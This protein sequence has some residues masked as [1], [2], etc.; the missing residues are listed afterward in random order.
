MSREKAHVAVRKTGFWIAVGLFF[1]IQI[2][3]I[4]WLIVASFRTNSELATNPFGALQNLTLENY[5]D[6]IQ[7]SNVFIY[8]KNS[9]VVTVLSLIFI[10][11]ISSMAA[12]A[13]SRIRFRGRNKLFGYFIIGL[14]IPPFVT[15]I[16]LY[17]MFSK[18]GLLNTHLAL[19]LVYIGFNLPISIL[20]FV[21]FYR[22]IPEELA[23]AA[24]LDGCNVYSIYTK[25][26][27]PLSKNTILTVLSMSFIGVWNDYLFSL[28]FINS[29]TLKTVSLGIQDFVSENGY[30]VW[31]STFATI[32]MTTLPTLIIY[33]AFNKKVSGG[34]TLGATK[35]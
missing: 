32:C 23:E 4:I 25:I 1:I 29:T 3:P 6:V 17:V 5:I 35:G 12:F 24:I 22:Y 33:F 26:Y 21:N 15:L 7:N 10:V 20:L 13:I 11:L 34:M 31:G 27:V 14:T 9:A 8:L 28:L 18:T 30:R 2:Y 16:P 19:V